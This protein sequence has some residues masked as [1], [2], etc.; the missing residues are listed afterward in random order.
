LFRYE[1]QKGGYGR[2]YFNIVP[3]G[4]HV[5]KRFLSEPTLTVETK[6]PKNDHWKVLYTFS[7]F[8]ADQKFKM[9]ATA[10]HRLT[11]DL[12]AKM[13]KRLLLRNYKYD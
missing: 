12:K 7:F 10:G 3:Y 13:F 9:T 1:I 6:V 4:K 11:F 8:Y 5:S 2:T